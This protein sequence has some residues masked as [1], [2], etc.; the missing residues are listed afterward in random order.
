MGFFDKVFGHAPKQGAANGS[1]FFDTFTAYRPVFTSWD[2]ELYESELVRAAVDARARHISKLQ[3]TVSGTAQPRL[4]TQLRLQPNEFQ[5]WGQFLYRLSTILDMKNTAFIVPVFSADG[6][7]VTGVYPL[8]PNQCEILDVGGRAWLRYTFQTGK[9]A[10]IPMNECGVMTKFQYRDEMFGEK[11]GALCDTMKLMNLHGQAIQEAVTNS[12]SYR[13]MAQVNNFT[14]A[15]DLAKERKRFTAENLKADGSGGLL[16]FP[17]TYSNI[18]QIKSSPFVADAEQLNLIRT[19]IYNYFGVNEDI[20]QN[21]AFGDAWSA[22]YEGC[23]EQ[24][25]VQFSDVL[26]K[27]LFSERER[28]QGSAVFATANRLQY[29]SN[30]DKLNVSAQMLD[31]GIMTLNEVREIWNLAPV[32]GGD[33]RILRGEYYDANTKLNEVNEN[34][35]QGNA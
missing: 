4:Q 21:K 8:I 16:L 5:T 18:Q 20:L 32:E 35:E 33:V 12:N 27:M 2:G 31:R 23:I 17:N 26:T 6:T 25:A 3:V 15:E 14:K 22:F 29:M 24:F 10:A 11:N 13:F 9:R 34:D 1:S 28:A 19:N 7:T 30:T